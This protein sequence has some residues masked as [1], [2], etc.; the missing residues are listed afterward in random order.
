MHKQS[1]YTDKN[2][3]SRNFHAYVALWCMAP[4]LTVKVSSTQR[5]S[6]SKFEEAFFRYKQS[7]LQKTLLFSSQFC[8]LGKNHYNSH[9]HAS[10]WLKFGAYFGVLKV[11]AVSS[12]INL[13][14][15]QGLISDFTHKAKSNF[16]YAYRVSCF[17]ELAENWYVARVKCFLV[18]RN[19]WSKRLQRYEA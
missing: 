18:V 17:K 15:I 13:I 7:N 5:R 11:K 2:N 4:K 12:S 9:M 19:W 6:H 1:E 8:T 14:I 3:K 16:C 10:I